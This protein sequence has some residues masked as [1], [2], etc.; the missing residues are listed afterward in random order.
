VNQIKLLLDNKAEIS[1]W[2]AV[3]TVYKCDKKGI[4]T[5][6]LPKYINVCHYKGE[7]AGYVVN[8][9]PL[10]TG[11]KSCKKFTDSTHHTIEELYKLALDYLE[12]LKIDYPLMSGSKQQA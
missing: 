9:Y 11:R 6:N 7:K 8:G 2:T 1:D 5:E 3:D 12:K 10:P 4:E